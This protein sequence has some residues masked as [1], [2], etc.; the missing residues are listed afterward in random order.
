MVAR[1]GEQEEEIMAEYIERGIDFD[2]MAIDGIL[3]AS[4][5]TE[6]KLALEDVVDL[7]KQT[8]ENNAAMRRVIDFITEG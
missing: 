6:R 8:K 2:R 4:E 1:V 3:Q 7:D 5:R